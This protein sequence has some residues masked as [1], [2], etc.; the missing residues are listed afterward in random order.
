MG[1]TQHMTEAI[2]A[3]CLSICSQLD[4][5]DL[6]PNVFFISL[7]NRLKKGCSEEVYLKGD[8]A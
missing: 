5:N 3:A 8:L 1:Q 7:S 4:V 2:T 6:C